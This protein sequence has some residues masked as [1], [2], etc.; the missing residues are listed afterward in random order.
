MN[1]IYGGL[2]PSDYYIAMLKYI[3]DNKN[4]TCQISTCPIGTPFVIVSGQPAEE[5]NETAEPV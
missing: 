2:S 5:V 4:G 1:W 3:S